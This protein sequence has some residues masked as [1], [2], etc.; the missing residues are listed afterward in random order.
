MGWSVELAKRLATAVHAGQVDKAGQPY[1]GHPARVAARVAARGGEDYE[2]IAAWLHDVPEDSALTL[3]DLADMGCPPLAL[4][5]I[6]QMTQKPGQSR[7]E[8]IKAFTPVGWALK[9]D[10]TADNQDPARVALLQQ[11]NPD[12]AARLAAKY[13]QDAAWRAEIV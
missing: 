5:L 4:D 10:D 8:Y 7:E 1:I 13:A 11:T 3:V 2:V 9:A 12:K 6:A